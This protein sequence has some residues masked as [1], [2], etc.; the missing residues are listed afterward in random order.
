MEIKHQFLRTRERLLNREPPTDTV[1]EPL[2]LCF[3]IF[4]SLKG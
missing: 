3:L 2:R 1:L 4:A